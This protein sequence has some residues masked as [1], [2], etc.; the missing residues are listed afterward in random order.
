MSGKNCLVNSH[1]KNKNGRQKSNYVT[2]QFCNI[3]DTKKAFK[4]KNKDCIIIIDKIYFS[5]KK[6]KKRCE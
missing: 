2:S 6:Q 4:V 3:A 5:K 1:E